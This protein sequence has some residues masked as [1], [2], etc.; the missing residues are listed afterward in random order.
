MRVQLGNSKV[1]VLQLGCGRQI[2]FALWLCFSSALD[3]Y[4]QSPTTLSHATTRRREAILSFVV[5]VVLGLWAGII[6]GRLEKKNGEGIVPDIVLGVAGAVGGG[7]LYYTF[8][9]PGV[10]G[11]NLATYY[12]AVITALVFLLTYYAIRRL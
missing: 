12:T 2:L 5:W 8:G 6:G 9:T 4:G 3:V 7:W 11:L 10:N 1:N